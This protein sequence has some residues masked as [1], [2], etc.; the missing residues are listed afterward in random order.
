MQKQR[1][2]ND[3]LDHFVQV[4]EMG[5][6]VQINFIDIQWHGHEPLGVEKPLMTVSKSEWNEGMDKIYSQ[7]FNNK[8]FFK[9]CGSCGEIHHIGHMHDACICQGCASIYH[10]VVY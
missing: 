4:T 2:G 6:N 9:I 8:H 10:G 7:I 1:K 3:Y 5:D